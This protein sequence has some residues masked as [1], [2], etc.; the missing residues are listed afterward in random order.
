MRVEILSSWRN[1]GRCV[2]HGR[3]AD[4]GRVN[5]PWIDAIKQKSAQKVEGSRCNIRMYGCVRLHG[6]CYPERCRLSRRI[7]RFNPIGEAGRKGEK[8]G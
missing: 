8:E 4:S 5:R 6:T 2:M 3:A 7:K 1:I